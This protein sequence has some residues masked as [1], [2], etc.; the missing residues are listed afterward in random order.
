[1]ARASIEDPLKVFRYSVVVD[2]FIRAGFSEV[3]GLDRT[4]EEAKYRE[5]GFNET[6]QKSAA[7]TE[8]PEIVLKRG[9]IIGSSRGGDAD[10]I[11]WATQVF[12]VSSAG[13]A[14]NYRK[15]LTIQQYSA[16]NTLAQA[17]NV[18]DCWPKGFKP[19]SDLKAEGNENS[20]EE[21]KLANEGWES[22]IV[23]T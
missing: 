19:I 3:T 21:L 5:G 20:F 23:G 10:F 17:W 9:Q 7:L 12:D 8:F 14:S 16:T 18:Y 1:M 22:I 2:G 6:S 15:D 4:T 13:N 11:T